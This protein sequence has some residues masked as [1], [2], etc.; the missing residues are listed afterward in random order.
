MKANP[1]KFQF[2]IVGNT[3]LVT[4]QS[5]YSNGDI[6][7]KWH[8]SVTLFHIT[9]DSKLNFKEHINNIGKFLEKKKWKT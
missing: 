1:D 9:V 7:T 5:A 4:L 3:G 8:L 6:A 2:V